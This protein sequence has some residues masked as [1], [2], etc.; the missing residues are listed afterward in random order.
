MDLIGNESNDVEQFYIGDDG[1]QVDHGEE[2]C[3]ADSVEGAWQEEGVGG[4]Q[5]A[6]IESGELNPKAF[7]ENTEDMLQEALDLVYEIIGKVEAVEKCRESRSVKGF[8]K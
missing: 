5:P 3:E 1:G 4:V 7:F 2:S 6:I 8:D